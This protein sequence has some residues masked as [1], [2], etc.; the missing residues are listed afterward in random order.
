MWDVVRGKYQD[1]EMFSLTKLSDGVTF[2]G[3]DYSHHEPH[4]LHILDVV[5]ILNLK[6]NTESMKGLKY[7]DS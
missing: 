2:H 1:I 7:K 5:R 6:L 4:L 3:D